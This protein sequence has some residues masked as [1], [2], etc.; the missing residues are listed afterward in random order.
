MPYLSV[1]HSNR[2]PPFGLLFTRCPLGLMKR[3]LSLVKFSH[4][5]FALPFALVGLVLG[6]Q[7]RVEAGPAIAGPEVALKLGLVLVCMVTARNAAMAFNRW[8][9]RRWDALNPRTATREIPAG[10]VSARTALAFTIGNA[11]VFVVATYFINPLC[12][13]LS[14]VALA[15]VLG[16]SYTK[17]FT[18]LCHLV[19]GVGLGLAP[20]GAYLAVTGAFSAASVVLGCAVL[21]WVAG[22]DVIYALQDDAF[23]RSQGLHS[24]PAWLGRSRALWVSRAL[25]VAAAALMAAFALLAHAGVVGYVALGLFAALLVRQHSLVAPTDL[26]RVNLAF[27]TTNGIASVAFGALFITDVLWRL[28]G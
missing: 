9:D 22:F 6:F 10:V 21:G 11:A 13:A 28:W 7:Q 14:P 25:H 12:F 26:S 16:Y 8:A 23:D 5:V 2:Q 27:F 1:L 15:V 17:R 19:L 18:A 4:T 20:V 3:F 24:L